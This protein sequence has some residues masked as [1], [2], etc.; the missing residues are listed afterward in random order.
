MKFALMEKLLDIL[1]LLVCVRRG[2]TSLL[3]YTAV[4]VVSDIICPVDKSCLTVSQNK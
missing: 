3:E 4:T 1:P 2:Q